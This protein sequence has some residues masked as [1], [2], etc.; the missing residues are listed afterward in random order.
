MPRIRGRFAPLTQ[1]LGDDERFLVGLNDLEK[2]MYI[3]IIFTTHMTHH[4]APSDPKYY[5][6]RFNLSHRLTSIRHAL[7]TVLAT[8]QHIV[9]T[10]KKLSLVKSA[11]YESQIVHPSQ[12]KNKNKKK[13]IEVEVSDEDWL[14]SL[15]A[16]PIFSHVNFDSEIRKMDAW[17]LTHPERKKTRRF[18]TS[19]FGRVEKQVKT[20]VTK[21]EVFPDAVRI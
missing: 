10:D 19:W 4:Q 7:D 15:K 17:L 18:M 3:L 1:E 8:Y 14:S 20:S 9:C 11:T 6:T 2:L 21:S 12:N 5:Q 13:N 16:N